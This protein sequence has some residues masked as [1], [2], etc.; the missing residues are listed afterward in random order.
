LKDDADLLSGAS[1]VGADIAIANSR[2]AGRWRQKRREDSKKGR[3]P[4]AIGPEQAKTLALR[5]SET[6]AIERDARTVEM[7]KGFNLNDVGHGLPAGTIEK[8]EHH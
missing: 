5:D 8:E 7:A 2:G 3:L 4:A 1:A 6:N